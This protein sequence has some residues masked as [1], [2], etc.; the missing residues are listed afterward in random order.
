MSLSRNTK[1]IARAYI[2]RVRIGFF[3]VGGGID[4]IKRTKLQ[5]SGGLKNN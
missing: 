2:Y 3:Q 1:S 4:R 5:I